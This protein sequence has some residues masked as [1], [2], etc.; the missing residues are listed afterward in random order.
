MIRVWLVDDDGDVRAGMAHALSANPYGIELTRCFADGRSALAEVAAGGKWDVAL[1][2]LGLLDVTGDFVIRQMRQSLPQTTMVAFSV[3]RDD[4]AIFSAL[5]AG[6]DGYLTKELPPGDIMRAIVAAT[7]GEPPLTPHVRR[8]LVASFWPVPV[9]G[10]AQLTG[11][12]QEVLDLLCT[13]ASYKEVGRLLEIA[14]GTVQSHV[15]NL[16]GKLG[17]SS[18]AEA[19]RMAFESRLGLGPGTSRS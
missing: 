6:A 15:K 2:D 9:R 1:V 16:Y 10:Q 14:E 5:R 18:K 11:R 8:R 7:L 3:R 12:E 17:A 13:G 19:V 4:Q